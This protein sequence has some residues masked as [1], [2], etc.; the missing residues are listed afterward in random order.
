MT[1]LLQQFVAARAARQK[2]PV[3]NDAQPVTRAE[4]N[5]LAKAVEGLVE[6][7]EAIFEPGKIERA[8]GEAVTNALKSLEATPLSQAN[9]RGNRQS[10]A[11]AGDDEGNTM[12]PPRTRSMRANSRT[13]PRPPLALP[14]DRADLAPKGD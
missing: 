3:T 10:L 2:Q 1:N 8:L 12:P 6:D 14:A 5:V 11:P 9:T 7:V 4:F 13:L